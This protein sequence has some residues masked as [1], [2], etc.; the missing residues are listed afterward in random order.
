[1]SI[2]TKQIIEKAQSNP[3]KLI[4]P[5]GSDP[6]VLKAANI[7][8]SQ[9]IASEVTVLGNPDE[10]NKI[11]QEIGT[12]IKNINIIDFKNAPQLQEFT[13]EY[14]EQRKHKGMTEE[15]AL[16]E[17]TD[18]V[19][20]GGKMLGNGL[21]DAMVSGSFSPTSKTLRAAIFF[22]KPIVKTISGIMI[23][24]TPNK[25]LG[26][27]GLLIFGDCA[28]VPAPN[29]EQLAD[30]AIGCAKG[31]QDILGI[32][33]KVALLSFSTKGSAK[34]PETEQ[35]VE[36]INILKSRN[37]SFEFDGELQLDAAINKETA[38]LKAPNSTIAGQANV[39]VF[40]NLS[41]GNIGY[42]LVQRFTSGSYAFGPILQGIT[43]P[44]NDLSRGCSYEDI[45]TT[46]AITLVQSQSV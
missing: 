16:H 36:A 2:F 35:V 14:Y 21:I 39:L 32:L 27:N 24:E 11:A 1:M 18:D 4:L 40:P 26:H 29:P 25:D 44:I 20:F 37:V 13:H 22:G 43:K 3:K 9:K 41:A 38:K 15:K 12:N 17:M 33:P 46:S 8:I 19:F 34:T 30:I 5:E 45:I 28:V 6:R 23:I 10:I 31:A 42:K 7:I